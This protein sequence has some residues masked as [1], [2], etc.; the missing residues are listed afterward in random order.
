[1]SSQFGIVTYFVK[2]PF[3]WGISKIKVKVK[4][5]LQPAMKAHM[6]KYKCTRTLSLTSELD[7]GGWLTPCNGCFNSKNDTVHIV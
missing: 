7:G 5:T 1:M 6:G 2:N 3:K 4:F